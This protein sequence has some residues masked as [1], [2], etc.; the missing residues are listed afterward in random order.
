MYNLNLGLKN[1]LPLFNFQ[2]RETPKRI[3]LPLGL[4][5]KSKILPTCLIF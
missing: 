3:F 1:M 4:S 2:C 5:Q